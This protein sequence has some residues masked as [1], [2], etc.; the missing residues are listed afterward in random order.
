MKPRYVLSSL[1]RIADFDREPFDV[2]PYSREEWAEGDYVAA[3]VTGAA[4]PLYR[5]ESASGRRVALMAGDYVIS[6]LGTRAA[7]LEAVGGWRDVGPDRVLHSLTGA[8]LLGRATSV[9]RT[10]PGF[11]TLD[12]VGH[13]VRDDGRLNMTD[14]V[15]PVTDAKIDIPVILLIGTS[16]SSG[17]TTTGRLIIHELKRC[18]LRVAGAKFTGAGRYHDILSFGD[19]GADHIMDFVDAGL[20][21]TVVPGDEFRKTMRYM[22]SRV[23]ALDIDV[24][25]AEAGASPLEPYN[26]SVAVEML[27]DKVRFTVL[28]A[29]DP[30]AVVGVIEAF[31]IRPD[32]VAGPAAAT[33]SAISLVNALTGIDAI[34]NLAPDAGPAFEQKIR[35]VL[36][37]LLS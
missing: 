34:D 5:L 30:Y 19:A 20:P 13:V 18:G 26:G 2:K 37:G 8:G 36:A 29:S 9:S 23:N 12:Y 31:G 22:I 27:K 14:F 25:V 3:R 10:L 24:L 21:S 32:L 35:P 4:T 6:A 15:Q 1:T 17:K 33:D 16:M 28:C 11:M 7:T